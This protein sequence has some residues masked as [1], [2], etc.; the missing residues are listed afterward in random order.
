MLNLLDETVDWAFHDLLSVV[1]LFSLPV[2]RCLVLAWCRN[3][4]SHLRHR[5]HKGFPFESLLP[6]GA[7]RNQVLVGAAGLI[8]FHSELGLIQKEI[9]GFLH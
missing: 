1:G 7:G 6:V 8:V 9:Y 4:I 2:V 3:V 5:Y